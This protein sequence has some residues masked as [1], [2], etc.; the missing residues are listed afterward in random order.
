MFLNGADG[1][2]PELRAPSI[3]GAL[4]F[5]WRALHGHLSIE[6]LKK[7]ETDI[8]GGSGKTV[9]RSQLL[10]KVLPIDT[11]N[12]EKRSLVPHKHM[13]QS[14]FTEGN[15]FQVQI[16]LSSSTSKR[17]HQLTKEQAI[18]LFQLACYLGGFG[19]R[20]RRGM[21]SVNILE[22][23]GQPQNQA[24]DLSFIHSLIRQ[25]STFYS[26]SP[27]KKIFYNYNG[28]SPQYGY[29][30]QIELGKTPNNDL[31]R[32]VSQATHDTKQKHGFAYDPSMGHAFKGRYASPVYVS[33]IK[34]SLLPIVTT[35]NLAPDKN[36]RQASLR[37]QEDFKGRIL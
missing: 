22:I 11:L 33:V 2:I 27:D 28:R 29:I 18:A 35:L 1:V 21:G 19:K 12:V 24:V 5:W 36:E 6:Q 26:L 3:K 23:D 30:T 37:I 10:L 15:Q 31:L 20:V 9:L 25:F 13:P 8:F 4:R 14:A 17:D 32:K 7:A 16:T 34:N